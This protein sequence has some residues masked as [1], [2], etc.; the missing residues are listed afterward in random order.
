MNDLSRFS[1]LK[2]FPEQL[3]ICTALS[4]ML[5]GFAF[6]YYWATEGLT[7]NEINYDPKNGGRN[8]L[9]TLNHI[10]NMLDFVGCTLEEKVSE[11]PE[12]DHGLSFTELRQKTLERVESI[13]NIC[14]NKSDDTFAKSKIKILY[15]GT[16]VEYSLWYLF[17]GPITDI[18]H[19]LGQV[20]SFRR[21]QG[22]PIDQYVQPF[23][24]KRVEP[25]GA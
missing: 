15:Q 7:E 10:Y 17:N 11:F 25:A 14:T 1:E 20:T 6:R 4:R 24:G 9:Q 22:N 5:D 18:F 19:H 3:S 8:F 21:T 12:K 2:D 16:P 13:Q 23:Q